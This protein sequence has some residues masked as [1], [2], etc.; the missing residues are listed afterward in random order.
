[1]TKVL[2][3]EDNP[4]HLKL[5]ALLMHRAGYEVASALDAATGIALARERLPDLVLMDIQLPDRNGLD[6]V[7]ELKADAATRAIP[8][9]AVT[10]FL[11][12]YSE[13]EA[14]EAGCAGFIAKPYHYADLIDLV[15]ALLA[16]PRGGN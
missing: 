3:V 10:S 2:I 11:S 4:T 1:M 16:R 9:I 12:E 5:A 8:V 6:A 14:L 15:R 7:R 13:R